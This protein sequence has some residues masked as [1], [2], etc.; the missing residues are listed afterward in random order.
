M[1]FHKLM[2]RYRSIDRK[3]R[4][5][6]SAAA[7]S[8]YNALFGLIKI[9]FGFLFLSPWYVVNGIY[10][11]F[12]CA[13]RGFALRE[14]AHL[15]ELTEAQEQQKSEW[16]VYRRS[17]IFLCLLGASYLLICVR[18]FFREDVTIFPGY[19]VFCVVIM[20]LSKFVSAIYGLFYDRHAQSPMV[21]A[22][23]IFSLA[24]AGVS[25][26]MTRCALL[27]ITDAPGAVKN[28]SIFGMIVSGG[29]V[30]VGLWMRFSVPR[31]RQD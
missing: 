15:G 10:Y 22:V 23:R 4:T 18:M 29:M 31:G 14:Y 9:L 3:T 28:S 19:A 8:I 25:L 11:L 13:G 1:K 30:A 17:G 26:V 24:D 27:L 20:S 16:Q 12:L 6:F 7:S 2:E 21:K 5:L